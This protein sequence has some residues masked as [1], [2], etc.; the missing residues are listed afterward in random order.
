LPFLEAIL[1]FVFEA[2]NT[3]FFEVHIGIMRRL[4]RQNLGAK[5][6]FRKPKDEIKHYTIIKRDS[7]FD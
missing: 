6:D 3:T 5:D 1:I 2:E 7:L 4:K